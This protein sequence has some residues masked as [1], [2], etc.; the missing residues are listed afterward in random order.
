VV[1]GPPGPH[2]PTNATYLEHL[3]N[4]RQKLQ[5]D[6]ALHFVY[7]VGETAH[8]RLLLTD[9][10]MAS[11]Y[12]IADALMFPSQQEGFGIPILEA[13]LARLPIFA[14]DLPPFRESAGSRAQLF[15]LDTPPAQVARAIVETLQEDRAFQLRRRVLA[16]YTWRGLIETKVLPL[17]RAA[18]A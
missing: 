4:L 6:Q 14:T 1:T 7:E 2:N 12:Q 17:L 9:E 15:T 8:E 16:H 3:L 11:F 10:E 13:A 5:L 18:A